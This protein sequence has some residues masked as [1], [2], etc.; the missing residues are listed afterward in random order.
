MKSTVARDFD[1][2]LY[3]YA[4]EKKAGIS[5]PSRLHSSLR[6]TLIKNESKTQSDYRQTQPLIKGHVYLLKTADGGNVRLK[7]VSLTGKKPNLKAVFDYVYYP[8]GVEP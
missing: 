8:P 2:D 5:S 6:K 4:N 1:N 7:L 3:I